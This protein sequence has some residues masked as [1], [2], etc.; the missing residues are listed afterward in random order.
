MRGGMACGDEERGNDYMQLLFNFHL[1]SRRGRKEVA[2]RS[3]RGRKE[4]A[5]GSCNYVDQ[6][7]SSSAY[8]RR[9]A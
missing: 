9:L 6:E 1:T 5:T 3:Q 7:F 4:V 2:R 8:L